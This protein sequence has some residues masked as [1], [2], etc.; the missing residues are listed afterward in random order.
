QEM[1]GLSVAI[2]ADRVLV[3]APGRDAGGTT[4]AGSVFVYVPDGAGGW[5]QQAEL[6]LS[7]AS[8][9]DRFGTAVAYDAQH[10]WLVGGAPD[11]V[12]NVFRGTRATGVP[13]RVRHQTHRSH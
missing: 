3:G 9:G 4:D 11:R 13:A 2:G 1:F 5:Q 12:T 6:F 8:I 7:G 10:G